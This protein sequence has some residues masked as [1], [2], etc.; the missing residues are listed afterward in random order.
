MRFPRARTALFVAL[1]LGGAD[2]VS[3]KCGLHYSRGFPEWYGPCGGVA[4]D[5]GDMFGDPACQKELAEMYLLNQACGAAVAAA[6][7][8]RGALWVGAGT[9]CAENVRQLK[10]VTQACNEEEYVNTRSASQSV[11]IQK[12]IGAIQASQQLFASASGRAKELAELVVYSA[13]DAL[14]KGEKKKWKE[15]E[16]YVLEAIDAAKG[17]GYQ[18]LAETAYHKLVAA[19]V[20]AGVQ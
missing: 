9:V 5:L 3:A 20:A 19:R 2:V 14:Y 17:S 8:T 12:G 1:L 18:S 11:D 4:K 13:A 7:E 16:Y 15:A 10:S 6:V